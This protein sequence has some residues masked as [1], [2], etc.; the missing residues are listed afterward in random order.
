MLAQAVARQALY[1][2]MQAARRDYP[3]PAQAVKAGLLPFFEPIIASG[4]ALA[5]APTPAHGLLLLLDAVQPTGIATIIVDRGN[6]LPLLGAAAERNSIL[7]VQVLDSGAFQSLGTV[8]SL[9]GSAAEGAPIARAQ[10]IY[11]NGAEALADIKYGNLELLPLPHGQDARL[12]L[13]PR[14][15]INAGFGPGRAGTLTVSG[16]IMG[17]VFD[18][19]GRP[20]RLPRDSGRRRDLIKKWLWTVGG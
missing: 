4:G 12:N 14:H 7:P 9:I 18:G 10:L 1:L 15:G 2:T 5:D 13:Q 6:L 3:R 17:V 11:E 19:R 16:G 20:L 8:V